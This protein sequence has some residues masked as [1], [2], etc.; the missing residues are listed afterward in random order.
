M[1]LLLLLL[2]IVDVLLNLHLLIHVV[3]RLLDG[4]ELHGHNLWLLLLR[5]LLLS[6]LL[7]LLH[8]KLTQLRNLELLGDN[9]MLHLLLSFDFKVSV[10]R[11]KWVPRG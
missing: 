7:E 11:E 9:L 6:L 3:H 1:L 5:L 10:S 4:L 2:L 8:L